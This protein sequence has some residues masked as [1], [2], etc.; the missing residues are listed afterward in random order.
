LPRRRRLTYTDGELNK[1][2]DS[3]VHP[4]A[5]RD[6]SYWLLD[7]LLHAA[8]EQDPKVTT[9]KFIQYSLPK[10][11]KQMTKAKRTRKQTKT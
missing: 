11:I 7:T 1:L 9:E 4:K 8:I 5:H 6:L 2:V 3:A 10:I